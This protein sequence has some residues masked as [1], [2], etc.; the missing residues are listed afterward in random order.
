LADECERRNKRANSIFSVCSLRSL[1]QV[2]PEQLPP[3]APIP[4]VL[5]ARPR[6]GGIGHGRRDFGTRFFRGVYFYTPARTYAPARFWPATARP[7]GVAGPRWVA[8]AVS[9]R[10][11]YRE[12]LPRRINSLPGSAPRFLAGDVTNRLIAGCGGLLAVAMAGALE[13]KG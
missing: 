5:P 8:R 6:K 4:S 9:A 3:P 11:A 10:S 13:G 12:R 2:R 7:V 1:G